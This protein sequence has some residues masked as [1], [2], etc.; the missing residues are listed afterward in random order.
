MVCSRFTTLGM[1]SMTLLCLQKYMAYVSHWGMNLQNVLQRAMLLQF[2]AVGEGGFGKLNKC[3]CCE[4]WLV[5]TLDTPNC[6]QWRLLEGNYNMGSV[7]EWAKILRFIRRPI[8]YLVLKIPKSMLTWWSKLTKLCQIT[9]Y[10]PLPR[11]KV[12][13]GGEWFPGILQKKIVEE[14]INPIHTKKCLS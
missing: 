7:C 6:R 11:K 5:T 3:R 1:N 13:G 14:H 4:N 2:M 9:V 12:G 10:W 8:D